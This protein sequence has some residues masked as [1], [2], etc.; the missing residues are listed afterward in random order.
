MG[1]G[2][3][4]ALRGRKRAATAGNPFPLRG[5]VGTAMLSYKPIWLWNPNS[6]SAYVTVP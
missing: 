3:G 1:S 2:A 6:E 4:K 5:W